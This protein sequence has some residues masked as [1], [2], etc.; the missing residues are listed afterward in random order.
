MFCEAG[1]PFLSR[2]Q[3]PHLKQPSSAAVIFNIFS[4]LIFWDLDL[5]QRL[6]CPVDFKI[7][8]WAGAGPLQLGGNTA[9]PGALAG[10]RYH[11]PDTAVNCSLEFDLIEQALLLVKHLE[12][13][14]RGERIL[15]TPVYCINKSG[16]EHKGR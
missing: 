5:R 2:P 7:I 12:R 6:L 13:F 9:V 3:F 8:L 4:L 14:L 16:P 11:F 1:S 10:P 15:E